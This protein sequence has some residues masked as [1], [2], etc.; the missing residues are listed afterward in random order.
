MKD[1]DATMGSEPIHIAQISDLHI[2]EPGVLAYGRVDTAAALERCIVALNQWQPRPDMVVI[3]GDL[4]DARR[5]RSMTISGGC[6]RR[7][8]C[9][10]LLFPAITTHGK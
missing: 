3:S 2:K 1:K 7:C 8:G 5:A 6:W 10:L 4:V 9:P